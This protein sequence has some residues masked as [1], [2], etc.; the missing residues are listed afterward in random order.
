MQPLRLCTKAMESNPELE[1][2]HFLA[3][4]LSMTVAT[5][6][7]SMSCEEFL[8]WYV[9]YARIRQMEDLEMRKAGAS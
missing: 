3:Q 8:H 2:E 9:Y 6:R 4:K 5:L 7:Q 1:F